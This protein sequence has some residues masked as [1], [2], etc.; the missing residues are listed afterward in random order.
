MRRNGS[1]VEHVLGKDG[2][3]GPIPSCGTLFLHSL[4]LCWG[5][6]LWD[7][8]SYVR[9]GSWGVMGSLRLTA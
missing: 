4:A 6:G 3:E 9:G 1:V 2:V 8:A 7:S 5:A